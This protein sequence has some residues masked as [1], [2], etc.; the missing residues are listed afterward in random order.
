[1]LGNGS[2]EWHK[3]EILFYEKKNKKIR[4]ETQILN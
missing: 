2:Y 3:V 1:M 4:S